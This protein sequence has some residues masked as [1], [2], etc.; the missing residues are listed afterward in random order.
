MAYNQWKK[1]PEAI[2]RI[3]VFKN[4]GL[5]LRDDDTVTIFWDDFVRL[6][7]NASRE[8]AAE[9]EAARR[10]DSPKTWPH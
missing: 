8:T 4:D 6:G 3:V 9:V 10:A 1:R 5:E 2:S 7:M